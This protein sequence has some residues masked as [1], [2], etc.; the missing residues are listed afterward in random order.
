MRRDETPGVVLFNQ[1]EPIPAK[2]APRV[3][4]P[5]VIGY[6]AVASHPGPIL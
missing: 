1:H 5:A 2:G 6:P 3:Q 4:E